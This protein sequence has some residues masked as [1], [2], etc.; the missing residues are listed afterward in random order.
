M[1]QASTRHP[2]SIL[3]Q[4]T[5]GMQA[6][7]KCLLLVGTL[8]CCGASPAPESRTGTIGTSSVSQLQAVLFKF[9][10]RHA[11][12]ARAINQQF[13]DMINSVDTLQGKFRSEN[14]Q[15]KNPATGE[16]EYMAT[17]YSFESTWNKI[18]EFI[19]AYIET[20]HEKLGS[21]KDTIGEEGVTFPEPMKTVVK[22]A[23]AT[24]SENLFTLRFAKGWSRALDTLASGMTCYD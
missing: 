13:V 22:H 19:C 4:R 20:V 9:Y 14:W 18:E 10:T 23:T 7:I 8:V 15:I 21:Y 24:T 1:E 5:D 17:V 6:W 16:T 2:H 11:T 12:D 3:Q